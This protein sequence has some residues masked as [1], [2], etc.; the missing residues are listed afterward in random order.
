MAAATAK[1]SRNEIIEAGPGFI[2]TPFTIL[3]DT[4]E[5]SPWD[6]S[7]LKARSFIDPKRRVYIPRV[8]RQW[9]GVG[10]GDYSLEKYQGRIQFE[11]KSRE[12][13]QGT[14]LGWRHEVEAG[15][16]SVDVDRRARFKRE[17]ARLAEVETKA[18]IVECTFENFLTCD[19]SWGTRTQSENAV[20]LLGTFLSWSQEF[21]SVPWIFCDDKQL[22]AVTAFRMMEQ[23]WARHAKERRQRQRKLAG[24]DG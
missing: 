14:L 6:F 4:A 13:A 15:R 7:G 1:N 8:E 5:K 20:Y 24:M 3:C 19:A 23:F 22:A 9:L 21:P 12:D 2:R 16:W 18:V 10:M 11:R 17:L